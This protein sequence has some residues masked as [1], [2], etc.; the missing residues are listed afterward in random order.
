M[1]EPRTVIDIVRA[2]ALP[3]QLLKEI[4]L[5]VR[6]LRRAEAGDTLRPLLVMRCLEA[7]RRQRER[8]LPRRLPEHLRPLAARELHIRILGHSVLAD[9]WTREAIGM[10]DVVEAEASL[11]AEPVLIG[12]AI[13]AIDMR[14]A[15]ALDMDF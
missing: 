4:G 2:E 12:R 7:G 11:D 3:D 13:A 1:A 8:L 14:D 6:A 10:V 5:L 9:E 15:T